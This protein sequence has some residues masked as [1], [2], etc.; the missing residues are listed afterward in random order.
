MCQLRFHTT[1]QIT[2]REWGRGDGAFPKQMEVA[3]C[4]PFSGPQPVR[5]KIMWPVK[6]LG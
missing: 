5:G 3:N 6:M 2:A 4:E 1:W